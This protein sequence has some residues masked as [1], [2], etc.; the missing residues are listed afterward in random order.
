MISYGY[1]AQSLTEYNI[2]VIVTLY[3]IANLKVKNVQFTCYSLMFYG[4]K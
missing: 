1:T 3:N 2:Y 4:I